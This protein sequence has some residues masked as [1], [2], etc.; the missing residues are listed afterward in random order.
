[1]FQESQFDE[2]ELVVPLRPN[3]DVVGTVSLLAFIGAMFV[4]PFILVFPV[5]SPPLSP[6]ETGLALSAVV[7]GVTPALLC[8]FYRCHARLVLSETGLRWRTWGDWRR[9]SW[10]GVQ[11][12]FDVPPQGNSTGD[13][14][15]TIRTDAGDVLLSGK[16]RE[17]GAVR[18]WVQAR[19]THAAVTEWGVQGERSHAADT[20]TF[21]YDQKASRGMLLFTFGVL[22]P[23]YADWW[24]MILRSTPRAFAGA[25]HPSNFW[26]SLIAVTSQGIFLLFSLVFVSLP[27]LIFLSFLPGMLD[28]RKR[29]AERITVREDGIAFDDGKRQVSANWDEVTG[30]FFQPLSRWRWVHVVE[31]KHGSFEY[32]SLIEANKQLGKIIAARALPLEV[33]EAPALPPG[34]TGGRV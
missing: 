3:G 1:M 11:D 6:L 12:Y 15:M 4:L 5:P 8:I 18:R 34:G 24:Y 2:H 21:R 14:L 29:R 28:A 25:W 16:W 23:L 22:L 9:A 30:N 19:A 33:R 10:D 17:S 32:T 13:K 26:G 31:T 20:R 7:V 27:L